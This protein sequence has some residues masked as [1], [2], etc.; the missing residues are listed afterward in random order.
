MMDMGKNMRIYPP[1]TNKE[2]IPENVFMKRI[3]KMEYRDAIADIATSLLR[4][5]HYICPEDAWYSC[6]ESGVSLNHHVKKC[7]CGFDAYNDKVNQIIEY[8]Q[9]T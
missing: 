8:I 3:D 5:E 1:L 4:T 9:S 2:T 6:P 7:D